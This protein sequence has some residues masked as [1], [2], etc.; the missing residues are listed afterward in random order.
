[1]A[2]VFYINLSNQSIFWGTDYVPFA[3][4]NLR[5]KVVNKK[6]KFSA[7]IPLPSRGREK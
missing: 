7:L 1:M 3:I 6:V 2:I 4:L 5:H